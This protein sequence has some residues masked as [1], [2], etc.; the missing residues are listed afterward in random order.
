MQKVHILISNSGDGSNSLYWFK[1]LTDSEEYQLENI[2]E[3]TGD[4]EGY[5]SGDGVQITYLTFPDDLDLDTI[6]V[7]WDDLSGLLQ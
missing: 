2:D 1:N 6:G 5:S 7:F 3:L 4:Y